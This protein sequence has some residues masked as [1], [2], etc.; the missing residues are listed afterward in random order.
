M[1]NTITLQQ[2]LLNRTLH[3]PAYQR[4][5]S[6]TTNQVNDLLT[7]IQEAI[8]TNAEHYLG[9]I[10]IAGP[11]AENSY[12]IVDGQQRLTTLIL[13]I[14]ALVQRLDINDRERI[15]T[16]DNLLYISQNFLKV[17]FGTNKEFIEAVFSGSNPSPDS[18]GQRKLLNAY[19]FTTD[20]AKT[21]S[22]IGN[23]DI[24]KKWLASIK[25]LEIIPFIAQDAGHAIKMFQ[26][27]NDRGMPLSAMD[28]AKALLVLYS[29]KYLEGEL[30]SEI[31][32]A[33]GNCYRSF[34]RIRDFVT[35][36]D[37]FNILNISRDNFTEDDIL[38]YH[39]LA[40]D[41]SSAINC[42]DYEGTIKTVFDG[43]LKGT[44][45]SLSQNTMSLRQFIE[46]YVKDLSD[47]SIAFQEIISETKTNERLYRIFVL[48]GLSARL[49]PL[50]IRTFQ[51]GL[52]FTPVT[53]NNFDIL[54]YI[55]ICDVRVY[56]TRGT[57]PARDIGAISHASITMPPLE[58]A[59]QINKFTLKFMPD[60]TF[61]TSLSQD[62]Y[63]NRALVLLL[64]RI[65]EKIAGVKYDINDLVGFVKARITREHI[66]SQTPNWAIDALGFD[67]ESEFNYLLH[68][69]G[70]LT[71]LSQSE[72]SLCSNH[73]THTKII[74][75]NLYAAS[76]Y[77]DARN[78]AHN[79][80][81][82]NKVFNKKELNSRTSALVADV[83]ME[84]PIV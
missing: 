83:M 44:L 66:I 75:V 29:S 60:G 58:I 47:F 4:D 82:T 50:I 27:V 3:I 49:Y 63:R 52:L 10:V 65:N 22:Q 14:H 36:Q 35:S 34:D 43:F 59:E 51:R 40:Y 67:D 64:I 32:N 7:D 42:L 37:G 23:A 19:N 76:I 12:E 31:N 9:T 46:N 8:D 53:G 21:L 5:Y 6:W 28:K 70:N 48:L 74:D 24:I 30:D 69:F 77:P 11:G 17:N 33:F 20:R 80:Q 41:H 56:K 62:M 13:I 38:R 18:A 16:E 26:T 25:N 1:S 73:S 79:Y 84:W 72:N 57:D 68:T 15:T 55:E 45:I 61:Q 81:Q 39:Y 78:I 54:K 71:L 2:F